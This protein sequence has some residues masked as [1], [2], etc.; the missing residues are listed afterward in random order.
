[1]SLR[2]R[3]D[4]AADAG[5]RLNDSIVKYDDK[6]VYIRSVED[7]PDGIL[8]VQF[9]ALPL[10]QGKLMTR[11]IN[12]PKFSAD[13]FDLGYMNRR[14]GNAVYFERMPVRGNAKQGLSR[15]NLR[16]AGGEMQREFNFGNLVD[17][18]EFLDML[19]GKYPSL[20][21]ASG[22]IRQGA[23]SSVAFSRHFALEVGDLDI[24]FL[25]YKGEKVGYS[26]GDRG[27]S[28]PSKFRYLNEVAMNAG[29]G[30]RFT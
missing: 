9:S 22:M 12:S 13:G 23:V 14:N 28:S 16:S 18:P 2:V 8:R 3:F 26:N 27:F 17:M 24:L 15:H 25:L 6:F 4:T 19:E 20:D 7:H 21:E 11:M 29:V 1:M 30:L 10:R 5:M